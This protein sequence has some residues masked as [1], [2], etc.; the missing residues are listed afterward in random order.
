VDEV[1]EAVLRRL[2]EQKI[3]RPITTTPKQ[4]Q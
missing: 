4:V 3:S 2:N 1:F